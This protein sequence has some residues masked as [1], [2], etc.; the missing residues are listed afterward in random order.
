MIL[1]ITSITLKSPLKLYRLIVYTSGI[2]RQLRGTNCISYKTHGRWTTHY[3]MSL[4]RDEKDLHDFSRSNEHL[5][6]MRNS[7]KIA[8]E[9][10]TLNIEAAAMPA[11]SEARS[12][13]ASHGKIIRF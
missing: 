9:I 6:A 5:Q 3:T 11:W 10:R 1:S 12:M 2:F 13:L 4:W 8:R 7:R